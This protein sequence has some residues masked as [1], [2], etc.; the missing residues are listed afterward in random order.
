M[1]AKGMHELLCSREVV[2]KEITKV[3]LLLHFLLPLLLLLPLF[4]TPTL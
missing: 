3:P 1:L 2:A 4:P